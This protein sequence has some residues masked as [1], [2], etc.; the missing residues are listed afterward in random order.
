VEKKRISTMPAFS[1]LA[2]EWFEI[3][4]K[5]SAAATRQP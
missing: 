3:W 4:S 2:A 1:A 5:R